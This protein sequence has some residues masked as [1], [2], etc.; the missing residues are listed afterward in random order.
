MLKSF[1][2]TPNSY[3]KTMYGMETEI[4]KETEKSVCRTNNLLNSL[5]NTFTLNDMKALKKP[6]GSYIANPRNLLAKWISR[7]YVDFNEKNG[8]ITK[9][10]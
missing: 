9:K 7:G 5:P 4:E 2:P 6:N 10:I 8:T 3:F 1:S